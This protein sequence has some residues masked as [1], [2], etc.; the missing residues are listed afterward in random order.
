VLALCFF[1]QVSYAM[2]AD[3]Y[4]VRNTTVKSSGA[5]VDPKT[6]VLE[7]SVQ[8]PGGAALAQLEA[9]KVIID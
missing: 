6:D 7:W 4:L 5:H 9:Y 2:D 3:G 8:C 1:S